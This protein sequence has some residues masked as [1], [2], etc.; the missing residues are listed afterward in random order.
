MITKFKLF[1]NLNI[2]EPKVGDYAL[3]KVRKD[4]IG[5]AFE[6]Y[7]N[8]NIGKIIEMWI[9]ESNFYGSDKKCY[10]ISFTNPAF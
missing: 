7:I 8:D 1:E 5:T 6:P 4:Q 2:D 3:C 10:S 9:D